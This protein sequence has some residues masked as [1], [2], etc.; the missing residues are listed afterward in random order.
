MYNPQGMAAPLFYRSAVAVIGALLML[1][2]LA[3]AP[4]AN[5]AEPAIPSPP[6]SPE[7][8]KALSSE[9][10]EQRLA[11]AR[12][13]LDDA[14]QKLA[15]LNREKYRSHAKKPRKAMLGILIDDNGSRGKLRLT[16]ITPGGG[17]EEAG[18][19]Y[20]DRILQINGVSLGE[21]GAS[22]LGNLTRVMKQVAPGDTVTL[23]YERDG[24]EYP[25]KIRTRGHEKEI[26]ATMRALEQRFDIDLD[27][28]GLEEGL[29]AAA[30]SV[31]MS[32]VALSDASG[33]ASG[34]NAT[35]SKVISLSREK[36]R[37]IALDSA[38]G[39]YF[40]VDDGVLVVDAPK[41]AGDLRN[42]DVL[43]ELDSKDVKDLTFARALLAEADNRSLDAK[44]LREGKERAVTL[45]AEAF[46]RAEKIVRTIRIESNGDDDM[47]IIVEE[48]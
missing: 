18:L 35:A 34:G 42:G 9:E 33:F 20:G 24:D 2:A 21:P 22:P 17:A 8:P 28:E 13:Q 11:D 6:A 27:L 26:S 40:G 31:A 23:V 32:A 36:P 38:L 5:G 12:R 25:A 4:A 37:L 41:G 29:A 47:E 10:L 16:G 19:K 48:D 14:A 43:L 30:Q 1:A 44:V 3:A 7:A 45:N 46:N 39:S 15:E